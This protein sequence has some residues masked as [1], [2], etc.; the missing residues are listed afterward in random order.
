VGLGAHLEVYAFHNAPPEQV[1]QQ[2]PGQLEVRVAL[3]LMPRK[4]KA[5]LH[6]SSN[7]IKGFKRL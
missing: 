2:A 3:K 4:Y 1:Q 7:R 6:A 5:W